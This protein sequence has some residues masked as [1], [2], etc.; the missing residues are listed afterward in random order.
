MEVR[1][2]VDNLEANTFKHTKLVNETLQK[3]VQRMEKIS[4]TVEKHTMEHL[5]DVKSQV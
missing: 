4:S 5:S 2:K 1:T 3:E